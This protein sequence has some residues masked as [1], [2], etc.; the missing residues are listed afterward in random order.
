MLLIKKCTNLGGCFAVPR[1]GAFR[2]GRGRSPAGA[3][4]SGV[5]QERNERAII[6]LLT[7]VA[8][9]RG[10]G[11]KGRKIYRE[12]LEIRAPAGQFIEKGCI[13]RNG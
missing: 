9:G 11:L 8:V 4:R 6:R 2:S 13:S 5:M 3:E 7:E 12:C 1:G 10:S